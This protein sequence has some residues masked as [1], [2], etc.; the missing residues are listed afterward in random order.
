MQR[1]IGL[2]REPRL[3]WMK[4]RQILSTKTKKV[5][6]TRK[7]SKTLNEVKLVENINKNP[8]SFLEKPFEQKEVP[9]SH[10]LQDHAYE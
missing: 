7:R 6:N 3:C 1:Q 5:I 8:E 4:W 10:K 9:P 2:L